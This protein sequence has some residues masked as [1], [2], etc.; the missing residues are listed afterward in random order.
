[1]NEPSHNAMLDIEQREKGVSVLDLVITL[2]FTMVVALVI[3]AAIGEW[4]FQFRPVLITPVWKLVGVT[5]LYNA[6]FLGLLHIRQRSIS[7]VRLGLVR[8]LQVAVDP[9]VFSSL[10]F[11]YG[12][13][14]T[15]VYALYL[16]PLITA[17]VLYRAPGV[18]LTFLWVQVLALFTAFFSTPLATSAKI[19]YTN[20]FFLSGLTLFFAALFRYLEEKEARLVVRHKDAMAVIA[21]LNEGLVVVDS[22]NRVLYFNPKAS[23]LLGVD[24]DDVMGKQVA[25]DLTSTPGG[26]NLFKVLFYGDEKGD[27]RLK[28]EVSIEEPEQRILQVTTTPVRDAQE[29]LVGFMNVLHDVTEERVLDHIKSE[30]ITILS[31]QLRTPLSGMRWALDI[32]RKERAQELSVDLSKLIDE[33]AAKNDQMVTIV[34]GLV[35][36]SEI[37]RGDLAYR[38]QPDHVEGVVDELL[39]ESKPQFEEKGVRLTWVMPEAS[40]PAVSMDRVKLK[41]ALQNLVKNAIKYT[42]KGGAVTV[43]VRAV[44]QRRVAVSVTDTG[45]GI[46]REQMKRLFTKFFWAK[47]VIMHQHEGSGLGLYITKSIIDRHSGTIDVTSEVGKGSTFTV[48]LSTP[49]APTLA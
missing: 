29:R 35:L 30:F 3:F 26:K 8:A 16:V 17:L 11:L 38:L 25:E 15:W 36:A 24:P 21:S 12:P 23:E 9:L 5:L 39:Q 28:N 4:F 41:L 14:Q 47:N 44:D 45:V 19:L 27:A 33:I 42:P 48:T 18:V 43:A 49:A 13:I 34:E 22:S 1:M 40:L 37:Q 7:A 2:R 31:H 20:L 10:V 6:V 32:I 46:P